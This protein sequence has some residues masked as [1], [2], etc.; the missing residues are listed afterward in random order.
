M[1]SEKAHNAILL[2]PTEGGDADVWKDRGAVFEI[3]FSVRDPPSKCA[4]APA[5]LLESAP[6]CAGWSCV[7]SARANSVKIPSRQQ[8]T[9]TRALALPVS[10]RTRIT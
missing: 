7:F 6:D 4:N 1:A 5:E 10:C 3:M 8:K 2:L 9:N